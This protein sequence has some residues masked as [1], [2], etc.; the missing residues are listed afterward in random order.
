MNLLLQPQVK[1]CGSTR[2][3]SIL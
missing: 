2:L 1:I 3:F